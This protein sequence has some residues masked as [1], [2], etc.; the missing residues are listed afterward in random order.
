MAAA[1][2][3]V[4]SVLIFHIAPHTVY[5]FI[6]TGVELNPAH[7][8]VCTF[9]QRNSPAVR[10]NYTQ[11]FNGKVFNVGKQNTYSPPIAVL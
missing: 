9:L 11:V 4:N 10:I 5:H 3:Q 7:C 2:S 6:H 1:V 8:A